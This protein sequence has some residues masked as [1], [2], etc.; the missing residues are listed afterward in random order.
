M[1]NRIF[2]V[3]PLNI[4][5]NEWDRIF[6]GAK[7][8][9]ASPVTAGSLEEGV[10]AAFK[11]ISSIKDKAEKPALIAL[12]G[13]PGSGKTEF[14]RKLREEALKVGLEIGWVDNPE[15]LVHA[16]K[17]RDV[18]MVHCIQSQELEKIAE[19]AGRK[20]D[21]VFE[22]K[23]TDKKTVVKVRCIRKGSALTGFQDLPV[24]DPHYPLKPNLVITNNW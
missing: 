2:R 9:E 1:S 7:E 20:P 21:L 22:I 8:A 18:L 13:W 4:P 19:F 6:P 23:V 12:A 11:L 15:A 24:S 5:Q 17:L 3:A 14:S 16:S 10:Q